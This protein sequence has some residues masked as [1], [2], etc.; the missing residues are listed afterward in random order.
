MSA[1]WADWVFDQLEDQELAE[2]DERLVNRDRR[3][4]APMEGQYHGEDWQEYVACKDADLEIFF[5][6]DPNEALDI[7]E[8]CRVQVVCL[9]AAIRDKEFKH[10]VIGGHT[11]AA[12]RKLAS[13]LKTED[14]IERW[15]EHGKRD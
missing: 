10:G 5:R 8:G 9:K 14:N 12:R 6:R 3:S 15:L 11:P 1:Q 7:C 13:R 4:R 2:P